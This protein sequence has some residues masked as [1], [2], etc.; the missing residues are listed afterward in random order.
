M[1]EPTL[2]VGALTFYGRVDHG[3]ILVEAGEGI[4]MET[5]KDWL[6][7]EGA[8]KIIAHLQEVF[9]LGDR[10]PVAAVRVCKNCR[11]CY[12]ASYVACPS[13]GQARKL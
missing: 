6:N 10:A 8:E 5:A 2:K 7:K 1:S 3:E 12:A 11:Q 4:V 13:C 9:E